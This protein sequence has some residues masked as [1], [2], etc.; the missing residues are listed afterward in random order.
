[1]SAISRKNIILQGEGDVRI[2]I[3]EIFYLDFI[4]WGWGGYVLRQFHLLVTIA[5]TSFIT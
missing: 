4:E 1:M 3:S 5:E 2:L